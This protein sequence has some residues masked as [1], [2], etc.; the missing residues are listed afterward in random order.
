M[1]TVTSGLSTIDYVIFGIYALVVLVIA[2]LAS[3]KNHK[4]AEGYFLA[5]KSIPWWAVGASLIAANISAEQFIG[6]A[7]SGYAIGMGIAAY[8]IM[9]AVTLIIVGKYFIPIFIEKGIY[10]IPEF[11]EKRFNKTLKTILAIFWISLYILVNL[12][13][14]LYLG[15]LAMET[16]LGIDLDVAIWCLAAFALI[17]SVYGGL[18]A[19][20]WTDVIQVTVL[21]LG[22]FATSYIALDW[23]GEGQGVMAGWST[24]MNAV[25]GHFEMILSQDN[26]HYI[27]LPGITVL[28]GG[29]W[30]TN[31]YY[32]GFNQYII[33]RTFAAKSV[34]EAQTGLIFGGFLKLLIPLLVVI[35]GIA[36]Y[37]ITVENP[38]LLDS[39]KEQYGSM[40]LNNIPTDAA[41]DKSYPWVAQLLPTGVKGVVFAALAAA[42]VSSLASML[43][44][45]ATIFTMDIYK[46]FINKKASDLRLVTVGRMTAVV[47]LVIA[48][49]IAP[50]LSTLG[51]AFQFIQ[52]YTGVVSPGI[53]SVFLCGLFYKKANSKGA[54]VGVL[55]SIVIAFVLKFMPLNMP[56]LNQ[57]FYNWILTTAIIAFV[58]LSTNENDDDEKAIK[59]TAQTFKT[60]GGFAIGAYAIM[61]IVVAIYSAL[62]SVDLGWAF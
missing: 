29:L 55:A 43:N 36:A 58:S 19:V 26:P 48:V 57:M 20:V 40:V 13:S 5:G 59:T 21:V 44:S 56:F 24:L 46:E 52:E 30:V 12:T 54:V 8:E 42:I 61:L 53:L 31:L 27:D 6:M 51:Q 3:R 7:G 45:T 41:P 14:V 28:I 33:Q 47:S 9:A 39:L 62:W 38:A 32:W 23:I 11:V 34:H 35:P 25:P 4:S 1:E 17:Y 50:V 60:T 22:G 49:F 37:Y 15:G 2:L 18:S 10:T 16:I